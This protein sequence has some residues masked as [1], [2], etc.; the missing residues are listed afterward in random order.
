MLTKFPKFKLNVPKYYKIDAEGKTL[1]RIASKVCNLL[2]GKYSSHYTP[3]V[4]QG[5]FVIVINAS[6][7][8]I[9][10]KKST[11][12]R[13]YYSTKRPGALKAELYKSLK[14]R[15]PSRILEKAIFG[16][17]PKTALGRKL[18]K[19]LYVFSKGLCLKKSAQAYNMPTFT[20]IC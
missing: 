20:Q 11:H 18:Y 16:M 6:L 7:I 1:G 19:R 2:T 9:S 14:V 5:N 4:D 8:S 15:L 13:Y 3:G 12:K 17:L 10:G